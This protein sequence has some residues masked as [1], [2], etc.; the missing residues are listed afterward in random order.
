LAEDQDDPPNVRGHGFGAFDKWEAHAAQPVPPQSS[1]TI[2]TPMEQ[3]KSP[4]E[5]GTDSLLVTWNG[6]DDPENPMNWSHWKKIWVMCQV[7]LLT[8]SVYIGSAIYTAGIEGV[9]QE[10]H[11]SLVAATL[12]LTLFVAGY[13]L[14]P[15]LWSPL[16]EMPYIGRMPIYL[17]TLF[18][19]IVLQVPTA[20]ATNF[21]MLLAFRFIT[22]FVGSPVLA[23]GGATIADIYAPKKQAY[24]L[25]IWGAFAVCA[26][27]MGPIV[28]GFAAHAKG[29]RWTIWE[30]TWLGSF[31][32]V[33][34]FLFFPETSSSNILYRRA[35]RL[36]KATGDQRHKSMSEIEAESMSGRDIAMMMLVRPFTLNFQEP[37]VLLLNLYIGLIYALFYLWFE[38]F[39]VVFVGIYHFKEQLFGLAF[40]GMLGGVLVMIPPFFYYLYTVQEKMFDENGQIKPEK[41]MT[42]AIFGSFII[43]VCLFWFGWTSRPSIHW[44]V[45]ILGS[46]LF[47]IAA[48]L[49]FNAVLSYLTDAYPRYTASVLAG[50][51]LVRSAF[52]AGFPLFG[53]AMY[54]NL[55]VGWASTLLGLL[56]CAFIPI[57]ILLYYYGERIRMASKRAQHH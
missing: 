48:L 51:D 22:G 1:L 19:Y 36:R 38:S 27:A 39:P 42:I 10:Y 47:P 49:L 3:P 28:G 16:S 8:F 45:P 56:S 55:G 41:R 34:L 31:T 5:E 20:L 26:P 33:L 14:G 12:G 44:I 15:M 43:P 52:G 23:T 30:L 25:T 2:V 24:G 13:G 57:P 46:A 7:S 40:L 9:M 50:N 53:T 54:H 21:G 32:F 35:V 6:P 29:W 18:L 11:V 37:I 17:F 4:K